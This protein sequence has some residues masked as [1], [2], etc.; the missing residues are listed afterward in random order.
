M[1]FA[2]LLELGTFFFVYWIFLWLNFGPDPRTHKSA[3]AL[4]NSHKSS[5]NSA[6]LYPHNSSLNSAALQL[7]E[8]SCLIS[9]EWWVGGVSRRRANS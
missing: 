7:L 8:S 6:A 4:L 3:A 2:A 5:L 9:F 1:Q